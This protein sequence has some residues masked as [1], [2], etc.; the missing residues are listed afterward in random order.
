MHK[1]IMSSVSRFSIRSSYQWQLLSHQLYSKKMY[2]RNMWREQPWT[3]LWQTRGV[4]IY[5][6]NNFFYRLLYRKSFFNNKLHFQSDAWFYS[7]G[8][9]YNKFRFWYLFLNLFLNLKTKS[10]IIVTYIGYFFN[11]TSR[12]II[13]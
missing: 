9:N 12:R 5:G 13:L 7:F 10:K 3:N 11:F 4:Y 6:I 2:I 8:G 1:K